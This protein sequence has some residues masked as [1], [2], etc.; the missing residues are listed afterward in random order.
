MIL[1]PALISFIS[2]RVSRAND[3]VAL[4]KP[5]I[6][7]LVIFTTGAG[8]WLAPQHPSFFVIFWAIFGSVLLVSAANALNMYIE[9]DIDALMRRTMN[10][11][12]PSKRLPPP[13]AL[14]FGIILA[15]VSVSLLT[16]FVNPLTGLL[17]FIAFISYVLFYTPLK[18]KSTVALLIGAVP[19]ALP[20]LMGW[21][22]ATGRISLPGLILFFILFLWQIP[23]FLAIAILHQEE[24]GRAGIKIMPLEKGLPATKYTLIRY[25]IALVAVSLYPSLIGLAGNFYLFTALALGIYFI[26]AAFW[27]LMPSAGRGWAKGFF[28]ASIVY[29]PVL[30]FVLVMN[31][32]S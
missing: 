14:W 31:R 12:L 27:G 21:T 11:P 8:I 23:H 5:R 22:A 25:T 13:V 28:L 7:G 17:G 10:R 2:G 18:Q 19:G 9:R 15:V 26:L 16:A 20:P 1:H 6:T 3:L 4:A 30:L 32:I 29:L 24:Y